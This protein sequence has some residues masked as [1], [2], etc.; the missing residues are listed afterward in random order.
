MKKLLIVVDYQNDF[1]NG[2]LGFSGAEKLEEKILSKIEEYKEND[3][4]YTLD[5]HSENYLE[6]K[7]GKKLPITH[8]VKG[9]EGWNLYGELENSLKN[10]TCFEKCTFGSDALFDFLRASEYESVELIGLVSNICIISN[11]IIAK[12]ALPE[13]E[14][15]VDAS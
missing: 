12:T 9:T 10:R 5:T 2:S 1:V 7:E 15:I 8:C 13:A 6:T 3:V 11:A 14:I 4:V